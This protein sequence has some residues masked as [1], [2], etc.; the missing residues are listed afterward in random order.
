MIGGGGGG[1]VSGWEGEVEGSSSHL[2]LLI[3]CLSRTPCYLN[4][5]PTVLGSPG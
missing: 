4:Q 1:G 5:F 2:P 3:N